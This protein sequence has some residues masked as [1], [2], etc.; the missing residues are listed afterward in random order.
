MFVLLFVFFALLAPGTGMAFLSIPGWEVYSNCR[1]VPGVG[2][3]SPVSQGHPLPPFPIANLGG[4]DKGD[5]RVSRGLR[6]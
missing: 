4:R 6:R 1:R 5:P 2:D 3:R